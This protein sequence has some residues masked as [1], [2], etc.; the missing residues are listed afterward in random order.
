MCGPSNA[1][2]KKKTPICFKFVP[3]PISLQHRDPSTN[4]ESYLSLPELSKPYL[5]TSDSLKVA[6]FVDVVIAGLFDF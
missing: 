4:C 6:S 5:K 2:K 3:A 1:K